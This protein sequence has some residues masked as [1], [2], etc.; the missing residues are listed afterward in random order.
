V[1]GGREELGAAVEEEKT[2]IRL[3]YVRIIFSIK[4]KKIR[5]CFFSLL[6]YCFIILHIHAS[7]DV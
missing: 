5:S 7:S 1:K 6:S 4:G 3:Y 2:V